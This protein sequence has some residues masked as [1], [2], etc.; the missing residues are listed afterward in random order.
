VADLRAGKAE[1]TR[2]R[3]RADCRRIREAHTGA[4]EKVEAVTGGAEMKHERKL[5]QRDRLFYLRD[6]RQ[7][8]GNCLLWWAKGRSG[9][10][11]NLDNAHVFTEKEAFEQHRSRKTD[12]PYPKDVIDG[13]AIRHVDHQVVDKLEYVAVEDVK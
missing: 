8:V 2:G 1:D 6:D 12:R 9:Y 10:T 4:G 7:V 5:I 13:I 11:C 3:Y